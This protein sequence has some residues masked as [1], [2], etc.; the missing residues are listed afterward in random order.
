MSVYGTANNRSCPDLAEGLLANL[1]SE[2][3]VFLIIFALRL[4]FSITAQ[5]NVLADFPT[6]TAS[7]LRRTFH[8]VARKLHFRPSPSDN[9]RSSVAEYKLLVHR[10]RLCGLALGADSPHVDKRCVG[11]LGYSAL[12]ILTLVSLLIPA[13]SLLYAP[14]S[15]TT[16]LHRIQNAPLPPRPQGEI[17]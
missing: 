12:G 7:Q 9:E 5:L 15:L 17:S 2:I 8:S 14:A 10:L 6:L 1:F 16:H 4:R 13:F 11:N 3:E